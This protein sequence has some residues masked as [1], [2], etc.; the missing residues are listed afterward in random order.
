M[1]AHTRQQYPF[2]FHGMFSSTKDIYHNIHFGYMS[3]STTIQ[4]DSDV[5][6]VRPQRSS[7]T[8]YLRDFR[9]YTYINMPRLLSLSMINV[10]YLN[11]NYPDFKIKKN[12]HSDN[13]SWKE[14]HINYTILNIH[15]TKVLFP[16]HGIDGESL[17]CNDFIS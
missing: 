6:V 4:T 16:R 5:D 10:S 1:L 9:M 13:A 8:R 7:Y 11:K 3:E 12:T 15:L 14:F 17:R 2:S